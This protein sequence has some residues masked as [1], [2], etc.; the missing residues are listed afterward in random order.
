MSSEKDLEIVIVGGGIAGITLAIALQK[1]NIQ[2]QV[3]EQGH[4]FSEIGAGVAFGP[5]AVHAMSLCDPSI[6]KSF[7]E[8]A[9]HNQWP[10]KK[11][12][13][14][15]QSMTLFTLENSLGPNAVHRADFMGSMAKLIPTETAHFRKRLEDIEEDPITGRLLMK[16]HDGTVAEADAVIGCDGIKSR[17]RPIV[18]GK[19]HPSATAQYSHKYAYRAVMPMKRAIEIIGEERASNACVWLGDKAHLLTF[20]IRGGEV[21]NL[22]AIVTG[23]NDWPSHDH[24]TLPAHKIDALKDYR[25]FGSAVFSELELV[26]DDVDKWALFD[27]AEHPVPTFYKGRICIS[28]DAAHATTPHHGA[29]AGFCIEDSA[30]LSA[31]LSVPRVQNR[32]GLEAGFAAFDANRKERDQ[33][34]IKDSRSTGEIYELNDSGVGRDF[35]RMEQALRDSF[36]K[37]WD[38]DLDGATDTAREDLGR[39]LGG[40]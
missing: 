19:D 17:T 7:E 1:H 23:E 38:Y 37:V 13:H 32:D 2:V 12:D 31:L 36:D 21:F 33:W 20:P 5:N 24:L 26:D 35:K 34:L 4:A 8:V 40:K 30:V 11:R 22:V 15:D 6:L 10:S 39:R 25:H 18:V 27:L 9:T 3:Y 29:G 28:G 14:K 16:F